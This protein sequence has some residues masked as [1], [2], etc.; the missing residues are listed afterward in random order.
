MAGFA[1]SGP[2]GRPVAG[3]PPTLDDAELVT[4]AVIQAPLR[5]TTGSQGPRHGAPSAACG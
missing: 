2:V 4:V 5:F 1:G 3:S